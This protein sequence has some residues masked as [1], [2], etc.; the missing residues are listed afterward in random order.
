M[1]AHYVTGEEELYD[2]VQDPWQLQNVV[3]A[4]PVRADLLRTLTMSLCL[5]TPPGFSW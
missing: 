5:P 1:F 4:R 2:L 3:S